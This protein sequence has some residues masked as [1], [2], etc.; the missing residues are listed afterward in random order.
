M[1]FQPGNRFWEARSS[2]GRNPVFPNPD[3]LWD[4]A[5]QYF[6]WVADNPLIEAKPMGSK[7]GP[8][9]L[10]VPKMRAMTIDGLCNFLDIHHSTWHD[11]RKKD[12]FSAICARV[13]SIIRQQK[14]E[15]AA[16]EL[17][18]HAIIARD[19]GLADKQTIAGD[20]ENPIQH[21]HT[22]DTSKLSTEALRELMA[23]KDSGASD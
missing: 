5:V 1:T 19:L 9:I 21:A 17:L 16:A 3:A 6:E 11:Y 7:M 18:N 13:E 8:E 15:G 22:L 2:H 14:F 4:A 12:E 20:A 23:A 10:P